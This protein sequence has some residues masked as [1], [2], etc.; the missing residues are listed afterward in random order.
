MKSTP[1]STARRRTRA[2]LGGIAGIAPH[3]AARERHRPE[4]EPVHDDVADRR[5]SE[6]S[7][8]ESLAAGAAHRRG[9]DRVPKRARAERPLGDDHP[10]KQPDEARAQLREAR[11]AAGRSPAAE[12]ARSSGAGRAR[13]RA[14]AA[15]R[16]GPIRCARD[17]TPAAAAGCAGSRSSRARG[18]GT[19]GSAGRRRARSPAAIASAEKS[20]SSPP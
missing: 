17:R 12:A 10:R 4:A 13:A 19:R 15:P 16:A 20:P 5:A 14:C 1:S 6:A 7:S 3:A 18:R 9:V 8:P 2:R 11:R